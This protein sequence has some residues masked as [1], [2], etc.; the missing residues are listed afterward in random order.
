MA[1]L[2][3]LGP[4]AF[5]LAAL[6]ALWPRQ[7]WAD[8]LAEAKAAHE[9]GHE[10]EAAKFLAAAAE[11][12]SVKGQFLMGVIYEHGRGVA[13]DPKKALEWY[14]RAADKGRWT[15]SQL[16]SQKCRRS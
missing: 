12:G 15:R 9:A 2:L 1:K 4:A 16:C 5:L 6:F 7:I 11:Q 3:R 14:L 8:P 10:E 13:E